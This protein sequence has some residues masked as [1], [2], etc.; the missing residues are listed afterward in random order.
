MMLERAIALPLGR[1]GKAALL[2]VLVTPNCTLLPWQARQILKQ[3]PV[4]QLV[5]QKWK[6]HGRPYFCVLGALYALYMICFTTCCAYRP[7]KLRSGNR[8]NPR[9]STILEQKLLQ[10]PLPGGDGREG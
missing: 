8:T 4:K 7:L 6:K 1:G 2:T 3:T 9:D 10:V 5:N